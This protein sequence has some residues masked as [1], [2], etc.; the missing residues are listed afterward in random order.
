[1]TEEDPLKDSN[2]NGLVPVLACAGVLVA[3]SLIYR[4]KEPRA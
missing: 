1:L 4:K 2:P 3:L